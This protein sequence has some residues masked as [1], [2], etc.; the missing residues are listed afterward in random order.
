MTFRFATSFVFAAAILAPVGSF[1]AG[2]VPEAIM[3]A[4]AKGIYVSAYSSVSP[5]KSVSVQEIAG[6]KALKIDLRYE[7]KGGPLDWNRLGTP[8]YA[9]R[10]QF[11][12]HERK[13]MGPGK[14]Y[15][16]TISVYIPPEMETVKT[17]LQ[18]FD[19][20]HVIDE[21]GSVPAM[22]FVLFPEGMEFQTSLEGKWTCGT[23]KNAEGGKT[24]I[25]NRLERFGTIGTQ[26]ELSGR[27][28]EMVAHFRWDNEDG[29]VNIWFDG[30]P[31]YAAKG[32]TL[33]GAKF[34]QFKFGPYRLEMK[35]DPGPVTLY[36]SH[37][38]RAKTCEALE[39]EGCDGLYAMEVPEGLQNLT[40]VGG[41]MFKELDEM[42]AQGR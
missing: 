34:V 21:N 38:A 23:Y 8:G 28:L 16:Y 13:R 42:R 24:P 4:E 17:Y 26:A 29:L 11:Y 5:K 10:S 6:R 19:M 31:V 27:W 7:W 12:E 39:V 14:D 35:G 40:R 25:C 2:G 30:K 20:K 36:Y 33:K 22:Q 41:N 15:W 32:D 3:S 18:L 1:A 37:V 9:Q